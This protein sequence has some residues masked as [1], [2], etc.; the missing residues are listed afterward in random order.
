MRG[1][2]PVGGVGDPLMGGRV[3]LSLSCCWAA[4]SLFLMLG[5]EYF[6]VG[7]G[8]FFVCCCCFDAKPL[9]THWLACPGLA[10]TTQQQGTRQQ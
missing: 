5:Q 7:E 4:S 9:L 10:W 8:V 3:S 6:V 2:F 1:G